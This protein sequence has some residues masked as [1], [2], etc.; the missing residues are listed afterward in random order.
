MMSKIKNNCNKFPL[1]KTNYT[2]LCV[3]PQNQVTFC[4]RPHIIYI[5][6]KLNTINLLYIQNEN[7]HKQIK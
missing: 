1:A 7:K 3:V 4:G 5:I 2:T 6:K